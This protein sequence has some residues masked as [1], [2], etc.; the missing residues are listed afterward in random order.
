MQ[1]FKVDAEV[2]NAELVTADRVFVP[3]SPQR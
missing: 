3:A 2:T 1:R